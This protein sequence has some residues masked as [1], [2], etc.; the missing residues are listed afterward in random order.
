M[1]DAL[2]DAADA[3]TCVDE[4]LRNAACGASVPAL[5]AVRADLLW[6]PDVGSVEGCIRVVY[7]QDIYPLDHNT[8]ACRVKRANLGLNQ[9]V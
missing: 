1:A 2:G 3:A 6:S 7:F 8:V 9:M 4:W 5:P